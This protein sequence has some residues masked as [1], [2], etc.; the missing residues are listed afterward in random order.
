MDA[1][2]IPPET[3]ELPVGKHVFLSQGLH[4][5]V[6]VALNAILSLEEAFESSVV[7]VNLCNQRLSLQR[8][9]RVGDSFELELEVV[10]GSRDQILCSSRRWGERLLFRA[11]SLASLGETLV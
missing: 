4:G 5:E 3:K 8:R 7:A 6:A 2:S 10:V 11:R 1:M 9:E